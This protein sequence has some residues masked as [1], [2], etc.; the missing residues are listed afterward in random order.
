MIIDI[1]HHDYF[2]VLQIRDK[3]FGYSVFGKNDVIGFDTIPDHLSPTLEDFI[4]ELKNVLEKE[5]EHQL[6]PALS[7]FV[8]FLVN[9]HFQSRI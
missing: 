3:Y 8:I 9:S 5:S 6:G 1:W 7:K 4:R 2:I